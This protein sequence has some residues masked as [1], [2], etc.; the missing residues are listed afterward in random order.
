MLVH[1]F[2]G[3]L[4]HVITLH[5]LGSDVHIAAIRGDLHGL[6]RLVGKE[7]LDRSGRYFTSALHAAAHIG[8]QTTVTWIL[9][10]GAQVDRIQGKPLQV[11][12]ERGHTGV[13]RL[14]LEAGADANLPRGE[15]GSILH[16]A[17]F[18]ERLE[19]ARMLAERSPDLSRLSSAFG[20]VLDIAV[21]RRDNNSQM[22]VTLVRAGADIDTDDSDRLPSIAV[23][24]ICGHGRNVQTL[25]ELGARCEQGIKLAIQRRRVD[26]ARLMLDSHPTALE[27][28]TTPEWSPLI[29]ATR[30]DDFRM[31]LLVLRK[32]QPSFRPTLLEMTGTWRGLTALNLARRAG[33]HRI[34][35]VLEATSAHPQ[36]SRIIYRS[37]LA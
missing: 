11:A 19:I 36:A 1:R 6:E 24:V 9:S 13:V 7:S 27:R 8:C 10:H 30:N 32:V 37:K 20:A 28:I 4:D 17:V 25:M 5:L 12:V 3:H 18:L 33:H 35:R 31:V 29:C 21:C 16:T 2:S 22:L 23:A 26:L 34:V 14:L 15:Y